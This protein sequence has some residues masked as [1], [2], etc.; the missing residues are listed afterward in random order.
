VLYAGRGS[1]VYYEPNPE[2]VALLGYRRGDVRRTL[3]EI[4]RQ[5]P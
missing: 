3:R 1:T 5:Y 4:V 2:E